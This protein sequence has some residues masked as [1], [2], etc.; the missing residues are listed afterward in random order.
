MDRSTGQ[1]IAVSR[2]DTLEQAQ[3]SRERIA[4]ALQPLQAL[5]WHGEDADINEVTH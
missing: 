4:E 3:F 2:F 1:S 5:G